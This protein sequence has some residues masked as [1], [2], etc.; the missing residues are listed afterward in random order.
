M[1]VSIGLTISSFPRGPTTS[2]SSAA[3]A[4]RGLLSGGDG[5]HSPLRPRVTH[6]PGYGTDHE[7]ALY[8]LPQF[9]SLIVTQT[10]NTAGVVRIVFSSSHRVST[11]IYTPTPNILDRRYL[12]RATFNTVVGKPLTERHNMDKTEGEVLSSGYDLS[13]PRHPPPPRLPRGPGGGCQSYPVANVSHRSHQPVSRP[14]RCGFSIFRQNLPRVL[15]RL[16]GFPAALH[17]LQSGDAGRICRAGALDRP[18]QPGHPASP[19]RG[20]SVL[21]ACQGSIL[22]VWAGRCHAQPEYAHGKRRAEG[23]AWKLPST[24]VSLSAGVSYPNSVGEN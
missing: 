12:F 4:P 21:L 5:F 18:A 11:R 7:E 2:L 24:V 14:P 19:H 23:G 20:R 3:C 8:P 6:P 10:V 16:L 9:V 1:V 13:P 22:R 17:H 15:R